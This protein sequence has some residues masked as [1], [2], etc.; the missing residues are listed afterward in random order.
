MNV[1]GRKVITTRKPLR[2]SGLLFI[3]VGIA[4][5]VGCENK[6]PST[7]NS[8]ST[9]APGATSTPKGAKSGATGTLTAAPNPI[10]VCDGTGLGITGLSWNFTG[11]KMVEVHVGTP[12]GQL[13]ITAGGPG[14]KST[15]KWVGAGT[16]FYLQDVTNGLPLTADNTIATVTVNVTNQGCP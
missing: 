16:T 3:A 4:A 2:V 13:L 14:I 6:P 9:P 7:S 11:A 8:N 1:L 5:I 12:D 15:G 10:Q